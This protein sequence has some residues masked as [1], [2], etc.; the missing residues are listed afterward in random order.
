MDLID[1]AERDLENLAA[2]AFDRAAAEP[3]SDES[4]AAIHLLMERRRRGK[5]SITGIYNTKKRKI[6]RKT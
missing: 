5:R 2:E 1:A 4:H 3:C 6:I